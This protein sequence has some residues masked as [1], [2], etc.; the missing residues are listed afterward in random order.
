MRGNFKHPPEYFFSSGPTTL[1]LKKGREKKKFE[2]HENIETTKD[3]IDV[4]GGKS[5]PTRAGC[6]NAG[7]RDGVIKWPGHRSVVS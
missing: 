2:Q 5:R 1:R 7:A 4:K 6:C 3:H